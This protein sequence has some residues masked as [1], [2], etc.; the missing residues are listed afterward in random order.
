M[1]SILVPE[2]VACAVPLVSTLA[3][4]TGVPEMVGEVN[5]LFVSVSVVALPTKVSVATGRVSTLEPETAGA[6]NVTEPE[7]FPATII[8]AKTIL[9]KLQPNGFRWRGLRLKHRVL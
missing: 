2:V 7:V 3:P 4:I 8:S 5:V 6:L 1:K 9:L